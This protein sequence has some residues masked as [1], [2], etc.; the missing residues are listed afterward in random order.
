MQ[1]FRPVDSWD[2]EISRVLYLVFFLLISAQVLSAR[3]YSSKKRKSTKKN[4]IKLPIMRIKYIHFSQEYQ[5]KL[6]EKAPT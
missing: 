3:H 6:H 2:I 1:K 4:C 5:K